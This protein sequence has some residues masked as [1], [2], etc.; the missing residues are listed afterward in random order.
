INDICL[1]KP[2]T[3]RRPQ[4]DAHKSCVSDILHEEPHPTGEGQMS[5]QR[6]PMAMASILASRDGAPRQDFAPGTVLLTEG[7]DPGAVLHERRL[8]HVTAEHDVWLVLSNPLRKLGVA[9]IAGAA[10]A[11]R[12]FV[13]A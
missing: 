2:K 3:P 7:V 12:R 4:A 5:A 8:M 9:K 1:Y 10:P 6:K 13:R 11:D